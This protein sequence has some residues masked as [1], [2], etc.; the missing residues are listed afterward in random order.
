MLFIFYLRNEN[1]ND[2]LQCLILEKLDS[3]QNRLSEG[4]NMCQCHSP[5]VLRSLKSFTAKKY[6]FVVQKQSLFFQNIWD[7]EIR[8][9]C[10]VKIELRILGLYPGGSPSRNSR[11]PE[12]N[13]GLRGGLEI[14]FNQQQ[15]RLGQNLTSCVIAP[16]AKIVFTSP[17][18][19]FYIQLDLPLFSSLSVWDFDSTSKRLLFKSP[20]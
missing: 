5:F 19:C 9:S 1:I 7:H 3:I 15:T 10:I 2:G 13:P 18:L 20:C 11:R 6:E 14:V 4:S 16:S 17:R 12:L 8:A